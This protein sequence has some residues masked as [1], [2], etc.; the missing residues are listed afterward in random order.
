M[1]LTSWWHL[2]GDHK[3]IS[4]HA[5]YEISWQSILML[6][7]V[8]EMRNW[9]VYRNTP[10][11]CSWAV[12]CSTNMF[13]LYNN[14]CWWPLTYNSTD[15]DL[16]PCIRC[17]ETF[18][19]PIVAAPPPPSPYPPYIYT[20]FCSTDETSNGKWVKM[21]QWLSDHRKI[22]LKPRKKIL[23]M[24]LCF[25]LAALVKNIWRECVSFKS[26]LHRRGQK[27]IVSLRVTAVMVRG[28]IFKSQGEEQPS[29]MCGSCTSSFH[30]N[31]WNCSSC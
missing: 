6:L 1:I 31:Y 4:T 22:T 17:W 24:C 9:S 19:C 14:T 25:C 20:V 23:K 10:P 27:V 15:T 11:T 28:A 8:T 29:L 5:L 12:A 7:K 3:I 26:P 18:N 13:K 21:K 30:T 2:S 16:R